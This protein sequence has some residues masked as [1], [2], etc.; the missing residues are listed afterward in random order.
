M[1]AVGFFSRRHTKMIKNQINS[2]NFAYLLNPIIFC[3]LTLNVCM[4]K[5]KRKETQL[6]VKDEENSE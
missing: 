3:I 2:A 6:H 5:K 4:N 1:E